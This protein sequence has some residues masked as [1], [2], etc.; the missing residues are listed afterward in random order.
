MEELILTIGQLA[1]RSDQ[2]AVASL[3]R[4]GRS[5]QRGFRP[6]QA[7]AHRSGKL[8]AIA[9]R[10]CETRDRAVTVVLLLG[11]LVLIVVNAFFV[12]A[13]F[14][15]VRAR[16]TRLEQIADADARAELALREIGEISEYLSAC[17][18]GVTFASIGIG[19]LGEPAIA[20]LI[21]PWLGGALSHGLALAISLTI[22]YVHTTALHITIGEQLPKIF[23]IS[24]AEQMVRVVARPLN[25]FATLFRPFVAVLNSA[26]NAILR[27]LRVNPEIAFEEGGTP[28]DL[29]LLITQS[30]EGGQLA[31]DE[32]LM[33]SGVFELHEQHA[34]QVM[35]PMTR[36]V[37]VDIS[38][39]AQTASELC[40]ES[41]HTRLLVTEDFN[42]DRIRGV[43]HA[44]S[45]LALI[46][47][48]GPAAGIEGVV[49]DALIAPETQPIDTLLAELRRT[50]NSIAVVV[51][52]YGRVSGIVSIEDIVEEIVGEIADE[53][54]PAAGPVRQLSDGDWLVRGDVA[55]GDLRDHGIELDGDT[56]AYSSMGGLILDILGRLPRPGESVRITDYSVRVEAVR[57]NRIDLVRIS[58]GSTARERRGT[59]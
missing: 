32:A 6:G 53:T 47:S 43:I 34:R 31:P 51:D 14:S 19:F 41:G 4:S 57:E 16:R 5:A 9:D 2:R 38:A 17:Q 12:A 1:R 30:L 7:L 45:L 52:E 3:A 8:A 48:T 58:R 49:R 23:A 35:T 39:D 33:L 21:H 40:I 24:R 42:P 13:E 29:K 37:T 44:N 56:A 11:M 50:R 54:D 18:L 15:L 55:L 20:E 22:A 10:A 46:L 25:W 36:V 26:S 27:L 59:A 28:E